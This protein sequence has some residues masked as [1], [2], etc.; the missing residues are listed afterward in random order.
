MKIG[1]LQF[2]VKYKDLAEPQKLTKDEL[3]AK[4]KEDKKKL[5]ETLTDPEIANKKVKVPWSR[6]PI[7]AVTSL[8][9]LDSHEILHQGWNLLEFSDYGPLKH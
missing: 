9:V 2:G 3:L 1:T 8:W 7:P 6:E 4:L 5:I